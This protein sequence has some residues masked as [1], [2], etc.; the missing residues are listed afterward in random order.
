LKS[1]QQWSV[2]QMT[3]AKGRQIRSP[4]FVLHHWQGQD[5]STT[6]PG[7]EKAPALFSDIG[8]G[9]VVPKRLAKQAV[10]RNLIRRQVKE[11]WRRAQNQLP[12]A[13]YV[14]RL[15]STFANRDFHS[16]ASAPLRQIVRHE[17]SQLVAQLQAQT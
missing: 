15:K 2:F 1:I 5:E 9:V 7:L 8:L 12:Q 6:G 13:L 3:M 17:L 10:T 11:V 14:V 16:A 4:H